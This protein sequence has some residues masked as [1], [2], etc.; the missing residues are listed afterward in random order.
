[1]NRPAIS[2]IMCVRNGE[3]Y[4]EAALDSLGR[5]SLSQIETIIIDDGSTDRTAILA[6]AHPVAPILVRQEPKGLAV[7]LNAGVARV[8][9]ELV[10]FLDHDDVWPEGRLKA[11]NEALQRDPALDAIFGQIVNTNAALKP[12]APPAPARLIAAM[13]IRRA[14]LLH[15]GAFRTDVSHAANVDWISRAEIG[16]LRSR[17]L[18]QVVLWRRVHGDNMGLRDRG[19]ARA[20]ML[21]VIRDHHNRTR[22]V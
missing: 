15:V 7:S 10:A 4:I 9:G 16:G 14:A 2:V 19:T 11:M 5:Q 13:L 21:R 6:A 20:D 17:F 18:D 12:I 8:T 3:T 1:M 22:R